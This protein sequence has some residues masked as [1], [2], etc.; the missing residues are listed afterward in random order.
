MK[1]SL[2]IVW[3]VFITS[4]L[5]AQA[6]TY[7]GLLWKITGNGLDKASYLYGTM[8][9]SNKVA[10][11]L[12]DSFYKAIE[13]VDVVSL[14]INPETWM[15]TMTSDNYVADNMGNAFSM[16]GNNNRTG[17]Y[18]SIF[19]LE[20]PENKEI[21]SVMGAE[22][23]I[24][25]SLLYRTSNY[26]A[27]FQEDTYLDLFIFQAG[28][29]QG[30]EIT[31]LEQLGATM[32]LN[33]EAARPVQDKEKR[34]EIKELTQ[35]KKHQLSKILDG[36]AY[37][38]VME[39]AY[40]LGDLD[41]LDSMSRLAGTSDIHHNLIIVYRNKGMANAMDSIMQTKSLFAGIG[42]AH[43]PNSYGVINLLRE[44]G[45]TVSPVS[46]DKSDYGDGIKEKL[47][48]TF[49]KWDF[50][51][52]TSFDGSFS[53]KMPGPMYEF[54]ESN[55]IMMAAYPDM[56][57][58]AKYVIT[59][60]FTFGAL[61]G[62]SQ[63]QYLDK[64]DSLFFE[65]IPGKIEEKK[66][67]T[68]DGVPGFDIHNK[69]KKGDYQRYQI[70]VTPIEIL[71][72][73]VSGKKEFVKRP[74]VSQF[75]SNLHF[76]NKN[77]W[78]S[79][80]PENSAYSVKMPGTL[81]C[82]AENNSFLRGF[83]KKTVQSYDKELGYFAVL[84]K[85]YTDMEFMEEDTFELR[86]IS[87]YF[88]NQFGYEVDTI[89][90][91]SVQGYSS[92]SVIAH[93][94][95]KR[96]LYLKAIAVGPQ[97]YLLVAQTDKKESA[98]RFINSLTFNDYRFRRPFE[99]KHDSARY[100]S[101]IT[102]VK[103]PAERGFNSFYRRET[104]D[105]ESHLEETK[106]AVYYSKESD[107][108]I[109][110]RM[111]KYHKY[112][113][114]EEVDS[115]WTEYKERALQETFFVRSES[116][117]VKE[118]VYSY[119]LEVGDT[120]SGRNILIKHY[121]KDG[122]L[123][124]LFTENDY[125]KPR[126]EFIKQFYTS[127]TPWDTLIGTPVLVNK[128]S[129]FLD[130]LVSEDSITREAA[131]NSFGQI[132][133]EDDDAPKLIKAYS[134]N[135]SGKHSLENRSALIENLAF[136]EHPSVVPF[137]VK[138]YHRIGDSVQFQMSILRAL[139]SQNSKK[140]SRAFGELIIDETPLAD[141]RNTIERLFYP[142]YDSLKLAKEIYPDVLMLT[143]LTEYKVP[144]YD[145]LSTLL[146]SGLIKPK[147]YKKHLKQ[148][149]WEA[150]N[151]IKRQKGSEASQTA[152]FYK[153]ES[154]RTLYNYNDLLEYY[155]ILLERY[156]TKNKVKKF[157]ERAN[158]INSPGFRIDIA[159]SKVKGGE[160]LPDHLW[161]DIASNR[162]D[163]IVLYQR[164]K[165]INR[166][167]LFPEKQ[168]HHDTLAIALYAQ[169]VR[170]NQYKDS[171]LF[172]SK[173]WVS[174]SKDSGYL[175]FYKTKERNDDWV[176]GYLGPID[177]TQVEVERYGYDYD[178][179]FNFNKYEDEFLQIKKQVREFEMRNHK[180]YRVSDDPEFESLKSQR[181]RFDFG[182]F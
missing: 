74:E 53:T 9:V 13:S 3:S 88:T 69:T 132:V 86:H 30:K 116:K 32:Q 101:V 29:K 55:N 40:R 2:L 73:Q 72:F 42:A 139:A 129:G 141:N 155:A 1:R 93:K 182:S 147:L 172:V 150:N 144:V 136:L 19:K 152:D 130:D 125:R 54:P 47:E 117:D 14:E 124:S 31:G 18:K 68:I 81:V 153:E 25:N 59:R 51:K 34:K 111:H 79:Y 24:L 99:L 56:A 65:N 100:F 85:S 58:G 151:E 114:E 46:R 162:N 137:L 11:H 33:E 166:L 138:E 134:Q 66:R 49:I 119:E 45:Y 142:F 27:D 148:L 169:K 60:M 133:F 143:A 35:K 161:S 38:E 8:H 171:L 12:S 173:H 170:V 84:N 94:D 110:I 108:T 48:D 10:F 177:T 57:N 28:K 41:L 113:Y 50:T 109:Y 102:N 77:N 145:L 154:R 90:Y 178:D 43:L 92:Y 63:E 112:Y 106:T 127:F 5:F 123:Y 128:V 107:E 52:Q 122:A 89:K 23:G 20:Q 91:D 131:Y 126:S 6:P 15:E 26:S 121:L 103:P 75:F 165:K 168:K 167:D 80:S 71:I 105:D 62:V 67:I 160:K 175:Y 17:F 96:D 104:E 115:I 157:F 76:Y 135:M 37:G 16:R 87:R 83:W 82:E 180:R 21:G 36:K 39:N 120:A 140:S 95:D 64:L 4:S 179:D 97:Y 163:R 70:M 174:D 158:T 44:K 146:D 181:R 159:I 164:L 22:L 149:S 176:Y 61:Y 7:Q 78:N 118:E 98:N 156:R